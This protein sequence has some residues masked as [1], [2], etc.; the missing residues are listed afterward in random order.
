[1]VSVIL[2]D[3][4]VTPEEEKLLK[5]IIFN[6]LNESIS[7]LTES[8]S[9]TQAHA[10]SIL[11][12]LS[13]EQKSV[14]VNIWERLMMADGQIFPKE[15]Q[16]I[17]AMGNAIEADVD[18][19]RWLLG[20]S[21]SV[22]PTL[23]GTSWSNMD[24]SFDITFDSNSVNGCLFNGTFAIYYYD[25]LNGNIRISIDDCGLCKNIFIDIL[26]QNQSLMTIALN[27]NKYDLIRKY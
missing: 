25:K 12:T 18:T 13:N 7:I 3:N 9:L 5:H 24:K 4:K 22:L 1:M 26:A 20:E 17:V 16:V 6:E 19:Y 23:Q 10:I 27:G 8:R 21:I 14:I 15:A 2:A 11:K